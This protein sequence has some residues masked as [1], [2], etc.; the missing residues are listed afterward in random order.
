MTTFLVFQAA[1]RGFAKVS[2][3]VYYCLVGR[4]FMPDKHSR[5][6]LNTL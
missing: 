1:V 5:I 6:Y 4:A 3:E 2:I